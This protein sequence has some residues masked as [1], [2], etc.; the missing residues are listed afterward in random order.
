MSCYRKTFFLAFL[1]TVGSAFAADAMKFV[2]PDKST[3]LVLV[4]SSLSLDAVERAYQEAGHGS[5]SNG[6]PKMPELRACE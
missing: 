1:L 2:S 4:T 3:T 6:R 5:V